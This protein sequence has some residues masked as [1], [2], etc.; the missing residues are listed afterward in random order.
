M[1]LTLIDCSPYPF[2]LRLL[3]ITGLPITSILTCEQDC[4]CL[5]YQE[6]LK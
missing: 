1:L 3:W 4:F 2:G 6:R 5:T